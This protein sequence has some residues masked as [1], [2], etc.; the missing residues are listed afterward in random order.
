MFWCEHT[1]TKKHISEH[2]WMP[3][4][5]ILSVLAHLA[6][7]AVLFFSDFQCNQY[8]QLL[9]IWSKKWKNCSD[10]RQKL[11][12]QRP[13]LTTFLMAIAGKNVIWIVFGHSIPSSPC[14]KSS[15]G[16]QPLFSSPRASLCHMKVANQ[17]TQLSFE[18]GPP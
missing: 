15:K 2:N 9:L 14:K 1:N 4:W 17:K 7:K 16:S 11:G 3:G 18:I 13:M 5:V 10:W 6:H 12:D 8:I